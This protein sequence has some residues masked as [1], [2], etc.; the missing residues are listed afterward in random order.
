[1]LDFHFCVVGA[2]LDFGLSLC[3]TGARFWGDVGLSLLHGRSSLGW[4]WAFTFVWQVQYLVILDFHFCVAGGIVGWCWTL[5]FVWQV[6]YS[7]DVGVSLLAG[8][9]LVWCWNF[10][11]AWQC[12]I[13]DF[14]LC[15]RCNIGV[16][17]DF[18]FCVTGALFGWC[19]SFTFGRCNFGLML[20]FQF[21]VAMLDFEFP[22]CGRCNIGMVLGFHFCVA[23]AL[24]R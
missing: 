7:G 24:F 17:L 12:L 18:Q 5:T 22:L 9:I 11:F 10:T 19:W 23:G 1:M 6:H 20:E 13:L 21:C 16:V 2:I 4:C 14:T 8:A 3:V 15:G